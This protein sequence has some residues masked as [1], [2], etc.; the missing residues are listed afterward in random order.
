MV[1]YIM[2]KKSVAERFWAK[3][4]KDG[5]VPAGRPE[6]GKC[7][8]W[9]GHRK[10]EYGYGIF[11]TG[12][13]SSALASRFIYELEMGP[14]GRGLELKY[15]CENKSC[16]RTSHLS[17][18]TRLEKCQERAEPPGQRF[19]KRVNKNGPIPG[20]C[21][22]LGRCWEISG[23]IVNGYRKF[24]VKTERGW[25]GAIASRWAYEQ[26]FGPVAPGLDVCHHCDNRSCVRTS[27]M[28]QGTR[29]ENMQDAKAKGRT[30]FG[31]KNAQSKLTEEQ[32]LKIRELWASGKYWNAEL[33]AQF[34]V[35]K[36][37]IS[38]IVRNNRWAYC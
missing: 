12:H 29:A 36:S 31:E 13:T 34:K 27:H 20:H 7:W 25:R 15:L 17:I 22:E 30:T 24:S 32:V 14:I 6:L 33:A 21:P 19:W 5:P 4:N 18:V 8:E 28:F 10:K 3:V 23:S 1:E 11:S 35:S 16:V 26:E 38:Q 37:N 2:Q 9:T